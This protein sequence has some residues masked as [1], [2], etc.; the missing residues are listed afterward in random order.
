METRILP[1]SYLAD[2]SCAKI[3]EAG[4]VVRCNRCPSTESSSKLVYDARIRGQRV[5]VERGR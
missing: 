4:G 1:M 3:G 5:S 2:L